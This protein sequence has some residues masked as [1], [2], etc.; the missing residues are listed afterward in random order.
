LVH[1]AD[2]IR[3]A[4][5]AGFQVL[6]VEDC[7]MHYAR[8]CR[9]WLQR[10]QNNARSCAALVGTAAYRTWVLYLAGSVASF[11]DGTSGCVQVLLAKN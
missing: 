8:T 1:L 2:V 10:L 9:A 6:S 5:K 7:R 11:E 3:E 4:E